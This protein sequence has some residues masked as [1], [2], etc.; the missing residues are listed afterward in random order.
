MPRR[1]YDF[2]PRAIPPPPPGS[3]SLLSTQAQMAPSQGPS[4]YQYPPDDHYGGPAS[5]RHQYD[6]PTIDTTV[7]SYP[8][9]AYGSP[10]NDARLSMS[11]MQK[12][13][14]VL[15]APLPASFDSQGIS[16]MARYG[17][18]AASV[19]SRFGLEST[20]PSS[21]GGRPSG[22]SS[23]LRNLHESAFGNGPRTSRAAVGTSPTTED[24]VAAPRALHSQRFASRTRMPMSQS[25]GTR[26][27]FI[28]GDEWDRGNAPFEEEMLPSS[29]NELLT[30]K[31]KLRRFSRNA[32]DEAT[33]NHRRS[34]SGMCSP[35]ESN[36][37]VG[38]PSGL[39]TSPSRF[40]PFFTRKTSDQP[41]AGAGASSLGHVG[42]PLRNSSLHPNA[43]PSLRAIS[44][45]KSGDISPFGVSSPPRQ[46]SMSMLT[47]ELQR[48]RISSRPS[49]TSEPSSNTQL[50]PPMNRVA[51]G[52]SVGS[53][54]GMSVPGRLDRAISSGSIGRERIDE[55]QGLFPMEEEEGARDSPSGTAV[56]RNIK[57]YSGGWLGSLGQRN[58]S[59]GPSPNIWGNGN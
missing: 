46:A 24:E 5:Q 18:I 26:G 56:P 21:V 47:Q 33:L 51:S 12:G 35:L 6:I 58:S 20:S 28:G 55:E 44:R 31:E 2:G 23:A 22:E 50:P 43:S 59:G 38:S 25:L 15:D 29:L 4:P 1:D 36:S 11:P 57:R 17:P 39:G 41:D 7:S 49:D 13:L 9:S 42:S 19:P 3:I 30:D 40:S 45:S 37:K 54:G 27:G 14:S 52:S 34:M 48:S 10:P 8:G 32:E 53:T 16:H